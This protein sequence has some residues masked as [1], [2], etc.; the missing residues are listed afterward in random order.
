MA[1]MAVLIPISRLR[2]V[3][4]HKASIPL[5][6][7]LPFVHNLNASFTY[8]AYR[9]ECEATPFR[10]KSKFN[11][12]EERSREVGITPYLLKYK[13]GKNVA[14]NHA[15][16][17]IIPIDKHFNTKGNLIQE[18]E[19][20]TPFDLVNLRK[21]FYETKE[22]LTN[23]IYH[24][25][26]N[27]YDWLLSIIGDVTGQSRTAINLSGMISSTNIT[28]VSIDNT[29]NSADAVN[30]EFDKQYYSPTKYRTIDDFLNV[31]FSANSVDFS[32]T[33]A[34]RFIYGFL[35]S[36]D[37]F[38][39]LHHDCVNQILNS[40]YSNNYVEGYWAVED[41]ILSVKVGC[42]FVNLREE[43]QHERVLGNSLNKGNDCLL[44]L[45]VLSMLNRELK[46]F[47]G[48]HISMNYHEIELRRAQISEYFNERILKVWELDYRMDYF[49]NRF[50]LDEGFRRVLDVA[51]PRGNARNVIFTNT[52]TVISVI[53]TFLALIVAILTLLTKK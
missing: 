2:R 5:T 30:K 8:C 50:R 26:Q 23:N 44:E 46:E 39:Q 28:V 29:L 18:D 13:I 49:I 15:V 27:L 20:C 3:F 42:P 7:E 1:K 21:A 19:W 38:M 6:G 25:E 36:N 35:R 17:L 31:N 11:G 45:C 41:S 53:I 40:F 9:I 22:G 32:T 24:G 10:Y 47:T 16:V 4:L 14:E 33:D 34:K 52:G 37:N 48:K 51:L 12:Y 43:E